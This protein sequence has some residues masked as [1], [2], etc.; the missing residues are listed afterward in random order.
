MAARSDAPILIRGGRV[1]DPANGVDTVADV[2]LRDGTVLEVGRGAGGRGVGAPEGARTIEAAGL[3]VAPGFVDLHTHLREP[4]F[5]EKETIHS[6]TL[7]AAAGG[8]TSLCCMPNTEPALDTAAAIEFV[9]RT[10]RVT[11]V[12]R[13]YPIGAITRGRKGRELAELAELA[14]VGAVAF[15]DDGDCVMDSA[16]MRHALEYSLIVHRP[17]VQHAEDKALSAGGVMHEGAVA[18]RLGLAGWPRQAEE[19]IVARDLQLAELT[20]A[21]L[22]VAHASSAGTVELLRQARQRGVRA[23]A[24]VTPHHLTLT[25][26]LVA[27][28]WWSATASL[29]PYDT[30]TKVNPPLRTV[31]DG[32]ALVA[33]LKEG[34]VDCIATDHAPHAAPDKQCEYALAAFGIS[35]LETALGS[36]LSLVHG[37]S[38]SLAEAIAAMTC[39]PAAVF[40]LPGGTLSPGSPADVTIFDPEREWCVDPQQLRSKGKNTPLAGHFLRGQVLFTIV[41]GEVV[42]EL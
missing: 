5:E 13:V 29:P 22:H 10:A 32:A 19:V 36:V 4:G 8:F 38:L 26:D 35:N 23:T 15:S 31:E 16:V 1:V 3:V 27:G 17:I 14:E 41:G 40:G 6:G 25:D 42:Y 39:R 33:G 28:R 7:A 34:V 18:A 24:E 2:L 20:G 9:R 30:S 12:V 37:G 11:G 21:H